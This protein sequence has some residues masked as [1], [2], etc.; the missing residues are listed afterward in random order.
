[1]DYYLHKIL[2]VAQRQVQTV[3]EGVTKLS[4]DISKMEELIS[5]FLEIQE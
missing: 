1:M 5:N 4:N 3:K 2:W